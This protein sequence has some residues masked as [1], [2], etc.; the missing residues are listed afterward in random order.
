[1]ATT[2]PEILRWDYFDSLNSWPS[3][4][5]NATNGF[6]SIDEQ[7]ACVRP[8][9]VTPERRYQACLRKVQLG[10]VA[11]LCDVKDN[12][13]TFPLAVVFCKR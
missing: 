3:I 1:M 6:L 11:T 8:V 13:G 10:F 5:G 7:S 4:L 12:L 2:H 9:L